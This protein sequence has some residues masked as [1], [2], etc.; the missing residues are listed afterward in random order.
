LFTS[1][2]VDRLTKALTL[3][4]RAT[5]I[6]DIRRSLQDSNLRH[7]AQLQFIRDKQRHRL[8]R[9]IFFATQ[10][11]ARAGDSLALMTNAHR[12]SRVSN[13]L[14]VWNIL[15]IATVVEPLAPRRHAGGRRRLAL[16]SPLMHRHVTPTGTSQIPHAIARDQLAE[17]TRPY[18][19]A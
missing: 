5:K 12:L 4:G 13:A 6:T 8:A 7:R 18:V 16:V 11:E 10:G 3:L 15:E 19:C 17:N 1:S 2:L 9:W 14:L